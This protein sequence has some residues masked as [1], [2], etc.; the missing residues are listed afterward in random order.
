MFSAQREK[1]AYGIALTQNTTSTASASS[2]TTTEI[3]NDSSTPQ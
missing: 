2:V 3:L 1:S